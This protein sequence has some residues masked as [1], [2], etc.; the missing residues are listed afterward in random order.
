MVSS[1]AARVFVLPELVGLILMEVQADTSVPLD[2]I[3][4]GKETVEQWVQDTKAMFR[5]QTVNSTF[6]RE[7]V[8]NQALRRRTFLLDTAT[9]RDHVG[10]WSL[11]AL[12]FNPL[13]YDLSR[14]METPWVKW[15]YRKEAVD[16]E[17]IVPRICAIKRHQG[18]WRS[19][20][21]NGFRQE[22]HVR[23]VL[24]MTP[25]EDEATWHYL[26]FMDLEEGATLGD[27]IDM[28]SERMGEREWL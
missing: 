13:I 28:F 11:P 27:L 21:V 1:A 9:P 25:P 6:H 2:Y 4:A 12:H 26:S 5:H 19:M 18:S 20:L 8:R 16:C 10:T 3:Y 7:V 17:V 22:T 23:L 14:I 24:R 15:S